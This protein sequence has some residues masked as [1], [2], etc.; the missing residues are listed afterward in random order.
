MSRLTEVFI[1]ADTDYSFQQPIPSAGR[2]SIESDSYGIKCKFGRF[3]SS[4]ATYINST[5]ILCLTPSIQIDPSDISL[6]NVVVTVAM[7]GID[8]NDGSSEISFTFIGT[9]STI[10][11]WVIIMGTLIF[12]LLIISV[13]VLVTG[14]KEFMKMRNLNN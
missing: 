12:G 6:E 7:N 1:T 5:T 13:L 9:G 10:S 11:T 14:M 3:G 2:N 8:F 4:V